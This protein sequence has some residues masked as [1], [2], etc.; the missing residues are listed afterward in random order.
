M[1]LN[2]GVISLVGGSFLANLFMAYASWIGV[3]ILK[4]WDM[5]SGSARQVILER[6]TYLVSTL[7]NVIMVYQIVSLFLLVHTADH[8]HTEFAG[9]MCAAGTLGANPYGY[10]ALQVKVF[11]SFLCGIW[12]LV[13]R[14][15]GRAPDYP[16]IRVKYKLLPALQ[17]LF[18]LDLFLLWNYFGGLTPDVITS[19]CGI[20]F[21]DGDGSSAGELAHLPPEV[22]R[23]CL[24]YTSPSP[25]DS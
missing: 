7:L 1:I 25:R 22:M 15:D 13:N 20:L 23:V 6:K 14:A 9:A 12:L 10:P 8:I 3:R 17:V 5:E 24:L 2:P 4:E 11:A 21:G 16:L 19:C 18:V